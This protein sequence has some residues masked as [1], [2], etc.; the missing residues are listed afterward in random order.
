MDNRAFSKIWIIVILTAFIA[1]GILTWQYFWFPEKK[2][3]VSEEIIGDETADWKIYKNEEYGYEIK[4]PKDWELTS[5]DPEF[6]WQVE[7]GEVSLRDVRL[8][9]HID[10]FH[11][12]EIIINALD[13]GEKAMSEM[14]EMMGIMG[15]EI[16]T[17]TGQIG[18]L[19]ASKVIF[20]EKSFEGNGVIIYKKD[21]AWLLPTDNLFYMFGFEVEEEREEFNE[22]LLIIDQ[23]ISTFRFSE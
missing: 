11:S 13:P 23:I 4:Y 7:S 16:K 22:N 8:I 15:N 2:A 17:E 5:W 21:G 10:A 20:Q 12:A 6:G 14:K 1:G 18:G 9:K 3:E 19:E